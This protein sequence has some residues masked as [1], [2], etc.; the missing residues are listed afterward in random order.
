M[1]G[2][3]KSDQKANISSPESVV[4]WWW[5]WRKQKWGKAAERERERVCDGVNESWLLCRRNYLVLWRLGLL[6]ARSWLLAESIII[7]YSPDTS[8]TCTGL[9]ELFN[10]LFD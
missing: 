10:P 3:L 8:D 6:V 4:D 9:T 2:R 1:I 7:L 5:L